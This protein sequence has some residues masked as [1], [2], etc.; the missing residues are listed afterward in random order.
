MTGAS[1]YSKCNFHHD[2]KSPEAFPSALLLDAG[3]DPVPLHVLS[4]FMA[5]KERAEKDR[6]ARGPKKV[7]ALVG[8]RINARLATTAIP[9]PLN[10]PSEPVGMWVSEAVHVWRRCAGAALA[11]R[12]GA[13]LAETLQDAAVRGIAHVCALRPER[14]ELGL[15]GLQFADA[16]IDMGDVL[17]QHAV[18]LATALSRRI[19]QPQ[20]QLDLIHGHVEGAAMA[21][22]GKALHVMNVIDAVVARSPVGRGQQTFPFVEADGL[23]RRAGLAGQV[24]D[25]HVNSGASCCDLQAYAKSYGRTS[26]MVRVGI[27]SPQR[28]VGPRRQRPPILRSSLRL[29][30][31]CSLR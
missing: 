1:T 16:L 22:E 26:P 20:Q 9:L 11:E 29:S 7:V 24:P 28:A 3:P 6:V 14:R 23:H 13:S 4:A 21:D 2:A 27:V 15:Q 12:G 31:C 25:F 10:V 17:V 5:P 30:R 18:D 8:Q 19:L